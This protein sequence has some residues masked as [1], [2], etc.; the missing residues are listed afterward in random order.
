MKLKHLLLTASVFA[1]VSAQAQAVDVTSQYITNPG[2]EESTPI[3]VTECQN[4][5]GTKYGQGFNVLAHWN[6]LG[7]N[8]YVSSGWGLVEQVKNANAGVVTYGG[9]VLYSNTGFESLPSAGMTATSGTNAMCFCGNGMLIYKQTS[10]VTLPVGRYQLIINVYPYNGQYSHEAPTIN[11]KCA[12]GF[13]ADNGTEYP[14]KLSEA[15][16]VTFNSNEW[17][18]HVISFE[19]TEQTTGTFQIYYGTQYFAVIDDIRLTYDNS[20]ITTALENMVTK[21]EAL[22]AELDDQTLAAAITT[23]KAFIENPT[24][25]ADV[26]PQVVT[27]KNAMTT[28]LLATTKAVNITAAYVENASFETGNA[29]PWEGAGNVQE[30][31]NEDSNPYINGHYIYD[32]TA[33]GSNSVY[34]TIADMPAGYY[35]LDAKVNNKATMVIN[36]TRTSVT[37]GVEYL[38]LRV[39]AAVTHLSATGSLKIGTTG[40]LKYKVD[41]FRLFYA[42]DE[43]SLLALELASVKADAT[44]ILNDPQYASV[45]GNERTALADAINGSDITAIN[46]A[47]NNLVTATIAYPK[48]A[49]AKQNAAAYTMAAYPYGLKDYYDQ[50]QILIAT[51]APSADVAIEIAGRLDDLC[52]KF[53]VSNF[54]CEGVEK[55]DYSNGYIASLAGTNVGARTDAAKWTDPKTGVKQTAIYGVKSTYPSQS[56]NTA[57]AFYVTFSSTIPEGKYVLSV[58]M[59]GSTGLSVDVCKNTQQSTTGMTKIGEMTGQGTAAGGKFGAGWNDHAFEFTRNAGENN[60]IFYCLPAENYKEWYVANIRLYHVT[61]ETQGIETIDN[62]QGSTDDT[63]CFDLQ[64]RKMVNGQ[65]KKGL[66]IING[67]KVFKK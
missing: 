8:D 21:A 63:Q 66:Y 1:A 10:K 54:Y 67:K 48:L 57:S 62:G 15:K 37:G 27:L 12:A 4:S 22:N 50:I 6:T 59:M 39:N 51:E 23:A 28:A 20:I 52:Y 31:I 9:K 13:V 42:K 7:G 3:A 18:E 17:N 44:A 58:M 60:I 32:Y 49:K 16:E 11:I 36:S 61:G 45:T 30:P 65:L 56:Q 14:A 43:A 46:T 29:T 47:A 2:F 53:Y 34:Q 25:Q 55:T 35:L 24:A 26:E 38:F 19:I 40:N 5:Y 33:A 64:G 41:D